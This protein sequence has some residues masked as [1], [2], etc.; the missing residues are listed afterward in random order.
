M[1]CD[2]LLGGEYV[3][4]VDTEAFFEIVQRGNRFRMAYRSPDAEGEEQ[5][6]DDLI[7][8][9]VIPGFTHE[10]P[11]AEQDERLQNR[12]SSPALRGAS[13]SKPE[14]VFAERAQLPKRSHA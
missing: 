6:A 13:A 12:A 11:R 8:E 14:R 1:V 9:G 3:N 5:V 4:F 7:Y 10:K 2:E